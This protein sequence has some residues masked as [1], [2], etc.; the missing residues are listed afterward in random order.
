MVNETKKKIKTINPDSGNDDDFFLGDAFEATKNSACNKACAVSG[1][2]Y[3]CIS[4]GHIDA[5]STQKQSKTIENHKTRRNRRF[6]F[7]I[8]ARNDSK[9]KGENEMKMGGER[10]VRRGI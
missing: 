9:R 3:K 2:F 5:S 4:I 1:F 6:F 8:L 7:D 10:S